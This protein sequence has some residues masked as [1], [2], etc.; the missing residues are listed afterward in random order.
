MIV[1]AN[2][3]SIVKFSIQVLNKDSGGIADKDVS[4]SITDEWKIRCNK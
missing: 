1:N 2:D 3:N 4:L